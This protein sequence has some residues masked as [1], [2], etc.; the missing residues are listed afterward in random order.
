MN[1]HSFMNI[2]AKT[3]MWAIRWTDVS[4]VWRCSKNEAIEILNDLENEGYLRHLYVRE[5]SNTENKND[6][7]SSG[8]WYNPKNEIVLN[9]VTSGLI[10]ILRPNNFNYIS[11]LSILYR[12]GVLADGIIPYSLTVATTGND[13]HYI[14]EIGD[15]MFYH[16]NVLRHDDEHRLSKCLYF[17]NKL[18]TWLARLELAIDDYIDAGFDPE[19][20]DQDFLK[21]A[22]NDIDKGYHE[23]PG[24]TKAKTFAKI[25]GERDE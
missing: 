6:S 7:F 8:V 24:N 10:G 25:L 2:L 18:Y 17:D 12:H 23:P 15:I 4:V 21:I 22:I 14:S 3:N 20:I 11:Y 13:G 16:T 5:I 19:V 9:G 1:N